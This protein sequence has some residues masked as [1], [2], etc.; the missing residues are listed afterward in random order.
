[1]KSFFIA[2]VVVSVSYCMG[3]D[4]S[5][6]ARLTTVP[7]QEG[8]ITLVVALKNVSD[9][10]I[11]VYPLNILSITFDTPQNWEAVKDGVALASAPNR[12]PIHLQP[13]KELSKTVHLH[14]YFNKIAVGKAALSINMNVEIPNGKAL[15]LKSSMDIDVLPPNADEF[16]T[17]L[18][19]ILKDVQ[20]EKDDNKREELYK[21]V[22]ALDHPLVEPILVDCL[23]ADGFETLHYDAA[24]RLFELSVANKDF[25][26]I[27]EYLKARGGRGDDWFFEQCKTEKITPEKDALLTLLEA[28]SPWIRLY[29]LKT[30]WENDE[31]QRFDVDANVK[32]LKADIDALKEESDAL[33]ARKIPEV[34]KILKG[35][36]PPVAPPVNKP[37]PEKSPG[38]F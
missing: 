4:L 10:V 8:P 12:R 9:H 31:F 22:M 25:M 30:F 1:M 15:A 5:V 11:D 23:S 16:K 2:L 19:K 34:E 38:D 36:K 17:R 3:A 13:N 33:K 29:T 28:T 27:A 37:K 32:F 20:I 6:E 24:R 35:V 26:V 14:D 7:H 21:S 18:A